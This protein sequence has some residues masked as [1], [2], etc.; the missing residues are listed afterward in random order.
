M[1]LELHEFLENN[2]SYALGA[3][4]I[5]LKKFLPYP[6]GVFLEAGANDG[7]LQSNTYIFEKYFGWR[8][9][10]VEPSNWYKDLEINRP[11]SFCVNCALVSKNFNKNTIKGD[12]THKESNVHNLMSST[13]ESVNYKQ[14]ND[15][16]DVLAKT[17]SQ[18]IESSPYQNFD[19][20]SLDCEGSEFSILTGFDFSKHK[21]KF[22]LIEI[23]P[24]LTEEFLKIENLL[25]ENKYF[26][27]ER[28]GNDCLFE[29]KD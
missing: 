19:L 20:I 24:E 15:S 3:L 21:T 6:N 18:V 5:V 7:I 25:S 29:K 4:D 1:I 10:L 9:I 28:F 23:W 11:N 27:V 2:E 17:I 22:F 16:I 13:E 14:D 26:F 8:G 12:F